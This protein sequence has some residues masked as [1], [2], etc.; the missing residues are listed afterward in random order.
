MIP[1]IQEEFSPKNTQKRK[2]VTIWPHLLRDANTNTA[3]TI[4]LVKGLRYIMGEIRYQSA[5]IE[6]EPLE[7]T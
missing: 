7:G 3:E 1:T 5:G 4:R 6:R 2:S